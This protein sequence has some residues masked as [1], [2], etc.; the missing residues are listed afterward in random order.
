[1]SMHAKRGRVAKR[2]TGGEDERDERQRP[3]D[4]G[5]GVALT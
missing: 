1:M 4:V 3:K 5:H 2:L